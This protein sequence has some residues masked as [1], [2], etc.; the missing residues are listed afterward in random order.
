MKKAISYLLA[1]QSTGWL[2]GRVRFGYDV[3]DRRGALR[4][5]RVQD[6][7]PNI[8]AAIGRRPQVPGQDRTS[9]VRRSTGCSSKRRLG[10]RRSS[11]VDGT[12]IRDP[13]RSDESNT[14]WALTGLF[15]SGGVP[16]RQARQHQLAAPRPVPG[17]QSVLP[18]RQ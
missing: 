12:T 15:L 8:P 13:G 11:A 7:Q 16:I 17:G 2:V 3:R 10:D 6:R 5:E 4:S 9:R 14:G 18:H 1:N